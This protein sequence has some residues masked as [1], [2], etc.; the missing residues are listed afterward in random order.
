MVIDI[1]TREVDNTPTITI[2][3]LVQYLNSFGQ[4][5]AKILNFPIVLSEGLAEK[6]ELTE[7]G[8]KID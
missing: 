1:K 8:L 7:E 2:G 3:Y 5:L 4:D 6:V